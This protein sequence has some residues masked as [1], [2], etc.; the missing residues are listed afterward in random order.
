M[1]IGFVG[2]CSNSL[3]RELDAAGIKYEALPAQFI[4]I[5]K[6]EEAVQTAW[7]ATPTVAP[8]IYVWLH[9]RN[10]REA[11]L[12]M[13]D[14]IIEHL[15][16]KTMEDIERLFKIA[17]NIVVMDIKNPGL[18]SESIYQNLYKVSLQDIQQLI[19][20]RIATLKDCAHRL[21]S[22]D[23]KKNDE[24]EVLRIKSIQQLAKIWNDIDALLN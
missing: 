11:L 10:S 1:I 3:L 20:A 7:V 24:L 8:V 17:K 19:N 12:T 14:N 5:M 6:C 4:V 22:N 16:G 13:N 2:K 9:K 23:P 21:K 18:A 15:E